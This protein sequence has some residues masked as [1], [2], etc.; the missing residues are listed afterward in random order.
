M[1][2]SDEEFDVV[3]KKS[4]MIKDGYSINTLEKE[5]VDGERRLAW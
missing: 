3:K 4:L 5:M 2:V 1:D